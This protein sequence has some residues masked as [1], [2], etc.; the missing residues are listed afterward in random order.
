MV[1]G[2]VGVTECSSCVAGT[3]YVGGICKP[4]D[5][6]CFSSSCLEC[7]CGAESASASG[8]TSCIKCSVGTYSPAR[9]AS[10]RDCDARN[11]AATEGMCARLTCAGTYSD[12]GLPVYLVHDV[13]GGILGGDLV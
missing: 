4:C 2:E 13:V 12:A 8:S 5:E 10:C 11:V 9:S 3:H 7:L 6:G 1:S